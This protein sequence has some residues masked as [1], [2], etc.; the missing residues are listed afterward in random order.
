MKVPSQEVSVLQVQFYQQIQ[1][2]GACHQ[3]RSNLAR[4]AI[5]QQQSKEQR[6]HCVALYNNTRKC[7]ME[8]TSYCHRKYSMRKASHAFAEWHSDLKTKKTHT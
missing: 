8:L 5:S 4:E 3:R 2:S 1:R 6:Q 7:S